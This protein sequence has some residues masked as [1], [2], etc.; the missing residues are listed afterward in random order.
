[1]RKIVGLA[2]LALTLAGAARDAGAQ[3]APA[4][5]ATGGQRLSFEF[6][7]YLW[8]AGVSGNVSVADP[9]FDLGGQG[10][11]GGVIERS[12]R[13]DFGDVSSNL[14]G[15]AFMGALEARYGR[16]GVVADILTITLKDSV[17]TRNVIFNGG[18]GRVQT[19]AGGLFGL[20]RVVDEPSQWL[21]LGVG[22]Q[23]FSASVR[24]TLNP[25]LLEGVTAKESANWVDP[26]LAV[27]YRYRFSEQWSATLFGTIGGFGVGSQLSWQAMATLDWR[28]ASWADLRAGWRYFAIDYRSDGGRLQIDT[29]VN[30]PIIGATF[31]F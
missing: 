31:R 2:V 28:V 10:R 15:F 21:D 30:G 8:I 13:A 19:T 22:I 14:S 3:P 11:G 12:I 6:T 16:F 25:G 24:L 20:Y 18:D 4:P 26:A 5:Q 17:S 1:M 29:A 23:P 27:R 7:P 9:R